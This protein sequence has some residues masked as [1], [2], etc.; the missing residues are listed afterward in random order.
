MTTCLAG[1]QEI[2]RQMAVIQKGSLPRMDQDCWTARKY[3]IHFCIFSECNCGLNLSCLLPGLIWKVPSQTG[4]SGLHDHVHA[5]WRDAFLIL[6]NC[7]K[8]AKKAVPIFALLVANAEPLAAA[9]RPSSPTQVVETVQAHVALDLHSLHFKMQLLCSAEHGTGKKEALAQDNILS[10]L[11]DAL[12]ILIGQTSQ[13]VL[14]TFSPP[15]SCPRK[16]DPGPLKH[17]DGK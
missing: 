11:F 4:T 7:A 1:N 5:L 12:S 17:C 9:S 15:L 8:V 16:L 10:G 6:A 3:F 2:R 13:D 14:M